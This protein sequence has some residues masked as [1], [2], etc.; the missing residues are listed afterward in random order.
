MPTKKVDFAEVLQKIEQTVSGM[1]LVIQYTPNFDPFFKGDLDGKTIFIGNNLSAEE[2]VFNLLH[3]A[4][5]SIQ[6]NIDQLLRTL[7]SELYHNP[8]DELL[9]KL[10]TYE[11]QA[12]CF[13]LSILHKSGVFN[14]DR[15]LSRKYIIDMLYLTHFYKTGEKLKRITQVIKAYPFKKELEIKDIPVFTPTAQPRTRNGLVISF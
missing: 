2:K 4:G 15:W 3:L 14:L 11:W 7:G 9:K 12:N 13:A 10:Q 1:D 6:W 8:D 5:H